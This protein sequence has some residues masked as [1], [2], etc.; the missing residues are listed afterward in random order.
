MKSYLLALVY[1]VAVVGANTTISRFGPETVYLVAFL[2]VGLNLTTRDALHDLWEGRVMANMVALI[3]LGGLLS[4]AVSPQSL[5]VA[6]A[7]STAFII[8][9]TT[10]ATAYH[11]LR[12]RPF[13]QRSNM[14]NVVGAMMDSLVFPTLAFLAFMPGVMLGQFVAKVL[15][16]LLWSLLLNLVKQPTPEQEGTIV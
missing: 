13:L 5:T 1:L 7:S 10:D 8:S 9:E 12:R 16:G 6:I 4:F 2:F 14:S 11:F 3:L 15:G